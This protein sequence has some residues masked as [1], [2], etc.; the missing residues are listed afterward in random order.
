MRGLL[1]FACLL[2][3][4]VLLLCYFGTNRNTMLMKDI[5]DSEPG[6]GFVHAT[7]QNNCTRHIK[8]DNNQNN[9]D[10]NHPIGNALI[11][12]P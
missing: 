7:P 3:P 11:E 1:V 6:D 4:L 9:G 2:Q 12:S 8:Q 10:H 5:A